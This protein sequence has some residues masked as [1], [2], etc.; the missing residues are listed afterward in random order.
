[1]PRSCVCYTTS[2]PGSTLRL[3][4]NSYYT[5]CYIDPNAARQLRPPPSLGDRR[6]RKIQMSRFDIDRVVDLLDRQPQHAPLHR[7][8][9]GQK[10]LPIDQHMRRIDLRNLPQRLPG[11]LRKILVVLSANA[12]GT[13]KCRNDIWIIRF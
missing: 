4:A 3:A 12:R 11:M 2:A 10:R 8:V 9:Q 13:P 6:K 5:R 1:M 7:A